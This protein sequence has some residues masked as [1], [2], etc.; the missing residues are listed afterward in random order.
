LTTLARGMFSVVVVFSHLANFNIC[1]EI[2]NSFTGT[3]LST[4][5]KCKQLQVLLLRQNNFTGKIPPEIGN[6]T[7]L[8]ELHLGYNNFEGMFSHVLVD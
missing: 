2:D 1:F 6:V 4:L 8:T 5:F 7:M 3:I